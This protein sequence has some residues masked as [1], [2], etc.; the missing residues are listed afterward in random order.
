MKGLTFGLLAAVSVGGLSSATS[1]AVIF[2][3][4]FESYADTAALN[5]VWPKGVGTDAITFLSTGP[6]GSTNTSKTVQH[7]NRNGRRDRSF[8]AA[9]PTAAEPVVVQFD[10]YDNNAE[11][12]VGDNAY[13]QLLAF[14][15]TSLTQLVA[16]GK[17]NLTATDDPTKYQ[18][19]IA[20]NS[21]NWITLNATRTVGWHTFRAEI[22]AGEVD[23]YVDGV[24]D[25]QNVAFASST[26]GDGFSSARIGT[27]LSSRAEL[28]HYD[29]YSVSQ[30]PEPTSLALIGLAG[31]G[32][33]SRRR[34][35]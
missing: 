8:A 19:R 2:S 20:F 26:L 3:D 13:N 10:L 31:A 28:S 12:G 32:L 6:A 11:V 14:T 35:A 17:S 21:T 23:F 33:L 1:A 7:D 29:N 22:F 5:A 15:G 18:A 34:R 16:M 27:G 30:V 9:I 24:P 4:D 25:L